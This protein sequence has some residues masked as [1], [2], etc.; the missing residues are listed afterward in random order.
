M[1][2]L[3]ELLF[4]RGISIPE[5]SLPSKCVDIEKWA[6]IACDQFTQDADYWQRVKNFVG[7]SPSTFNIIYPEIYLNAS[8]RKERIEKIRLT[9]NE[10]IHDENVFMHSRKAGVFIKRKCNHGVRTGFLTLIDLEKYDWHKGSTSLIRATE[11]TIVE[12]IPARVEIRSGA[13]LECPHIQLLINDE[14]NILMQLLENVLIGAP[15][16]Y[17]NNLMLGGGSVQ[18]TL[19]SR[20]ND[21]AF[22]ADSLEYLERK[23]ITKFETS[24]V[25]AVGDGNHSLAAAKDVWERYKA[26]HSNI[27]KF[28]PLRW[29][30]AEI[31]NLYDKALVF[32]PIHRVMMGISLDDVLGALKS[33]PDFSCSDID[34]KQKLIESVQSDA[35]ENR[36]G[37]I[38]KDRFVLVKSRGG[39]AA[40]IDME[41][42]LQSLIKNSGSIDYIHGEKELFRVATNGNVGIMLPPFKKDGFF[43]SIAKNGP[44]PRK[45]FSMGDAEEKRYY[46]E[47]RKLS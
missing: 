30:L 21:W 7:D 32:E 9:M 46:L 13:L 34:S 47:C 20:Q 36:Y 35:D 8:D 41:P 16:A 38:S 26:T 2:D 39:Y 24:F 37:L 25:F 18:G 19:L 28:F 6:V 10:Y 4:A 23:S 1:Q 40:T 33:M 27:P 15:S 43:K 14:E 44:L 29:A 11:E 22:I 31:V 3:I 45:S 17:N 5:I 42:I 12:R